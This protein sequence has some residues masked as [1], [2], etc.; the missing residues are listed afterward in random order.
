[1]SRKLFDVGYAFINLILMLAFGFAVAQAQESQNLTDYSIFIPAVSHGP[2]SHGVA[3]Q[4]VVKQ[5]VPISGV[6]IRTDRGLS[7]TT[8]QNG[9]C[10]LVG[11]DAGTYKLT[12]SL[13]GTVFCRHLLRWSSLQMKFSAY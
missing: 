8:D 9:K 6:T 1:M 12:P 2:T 13:A 10:S 5:N 4:V 7:A 11:L 3:G